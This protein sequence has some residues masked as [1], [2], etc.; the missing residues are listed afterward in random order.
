MPGR[1]DFPVLGKD[2]GL[3]QQGSRHNNLVVQLREGIDFRYLSEGGQIERGNDE[4]ASLLDLPQQFCEIEVD[5]LLSA[6][7]E[8]SASTM[9]GITIGNSPFS[10]RSNILAAFRPR[11]GSPVKYQPRAWASARYTLCDSVK[12]P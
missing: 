8:S 5:P 6:D 2:L 1:S 7:V 4:V 12:T 3:V 10:E 11:R 9:L